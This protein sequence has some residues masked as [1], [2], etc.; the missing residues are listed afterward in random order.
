[1]AVPASADIKSLHG[2]VCQINHVFSGSVTYS[3]EDGVTVSGGAYLVC[4]IM[5]DRINSSTSLSEV[6][7]E[8]DVFGGGVLCTLSSQGEDGSAG[9]TV[10]TDSDEIYADGQLDFVVDSSSGNEGAYGLFCDTSNASILHIHVNESNSAT[11]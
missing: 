9:S 8:V 6:V 5:R 3:A 10:D 11:D 4:P 2:A 7:V 1:V